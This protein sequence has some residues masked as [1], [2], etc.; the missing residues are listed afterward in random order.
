MDGTLTDHDPTGR[1]RFLQQDPKDWD[2]FHADAEKNMVN[3]PPC[4][5]II[6]L[7]QTL[8]DCDPPPDI[9]IVTGRKERY[10]KQTIQWLVRHDIP[11]DR[12]FMRKEDDHRQDYVI[13]Q[14]I[15]MP[16]KDEIVCVFEDRDQC[17]EMYRSMGI[18]CCQVAPGEF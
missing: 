11:Y 7:I 15:V 16:F 10:R 12:L 18:T 1:V 5:D 3:D 8:V 6:L 17:V 13:K 4:R 9:Y 2:S 14:E